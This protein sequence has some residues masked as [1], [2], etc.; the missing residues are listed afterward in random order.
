MCVYK[1]ELRTGCNS[2][3][4]VR[5]NVIKLRKKWDSVTYVLVYVYVA[6]IQTK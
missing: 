6:K 2:V 1:V 5:A 4:H 3:S